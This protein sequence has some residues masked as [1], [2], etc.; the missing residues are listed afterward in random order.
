MSDNVGLNLQNARMNKNLTSSQAAELVGVAKSTWSL[1]ER[2]KRVPSLQTLVR[3]SKVL[4][5][6]IDEIAGIKGK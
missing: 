5:V 2:N 1:Y 3:I 4:N 6:S